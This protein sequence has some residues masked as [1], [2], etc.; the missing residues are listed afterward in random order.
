M[1]VLSLPAIDDFE[2][3]E[4]RLEHSLVSLSKWESLHKKSF[5]NTIEKTPEEF[6]S[7]L[8]FMVL[9]ENPPANYQ[10]RFTPEHLVE[11]S[12]YINDPQTA[13]TFREDPNEKKSREVIT[14]EM[15]YYWLVAFNINFQPVETWHLNRLMTLVR[16]CGIKQTKPKKMTAKQQLAQNRS[17]NE[18]R[19]RQLG[20]N[21]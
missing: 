10:D 15:I 7:Y 9:D 12:T 21:G 4:L 5:Y 2:A 20:T 16:I 18:Q 1:L 17:L 14:S 19:R 13:T 6:L 8:S 3:A 11:V